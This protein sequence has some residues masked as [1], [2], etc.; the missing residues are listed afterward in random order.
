MHLLKDNYRP[1][2]W[3]ISVIPALWETKEGGSL[4]HR[5]LRPAWTTQQDS[6]SKL[7]KIKPD[8]VV[9]VVLATREAEV[10]GSLEPW[11]SRLW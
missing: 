10:R 3:L 8:V 1:A 5:S 2:Q 6:V 7:L 4:K 9:P 11:R